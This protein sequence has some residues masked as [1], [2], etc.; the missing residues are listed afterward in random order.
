MGTLLHI[1]EVLPDGLLEARPTQLADLLGG[2][3]LIHLPGRRTQPLFVSVLLHGNETTG[4]QALQALLKRYRDK[5]LPRALS[6]FIG[7][8][9]AAK[10]G[11]RRLAGQPDYNRI[12]PGSDHPDSPEKRMMEEVFSIMQQRQPYASVDVHNN[13]GINPHYAC[14]NRIDHRYMHLASMF[15]RTLVYFIR[16]VGVQSMAFAQLCP[17]L[18][19]E[20]GK[21]EQSAGKVHAQEFLDACLHLSEIPQHPVAAHDVDLFHTVAIVRVPRAYSFG[22]GEQ[23]VDICF[24]NDL[25]HLNF[26]ELPAGTTLAHLDGVDGMPLE[27][28]D[29]SGQE[30]ADRYFRV[31]DAMLRTTR[32]LMPS[33]F[34]LDERVIRQDCLGYLMERYP[35][36]G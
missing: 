21:V 17:A 2:P 10:D 20:C 11:L 35:L 34:T 26:R 4:F 19:V 16:P 25:D 27:A 5:E 32:A 7:N 9:E 36:P 15:S 6:I 14:I 22:F 31:E 24:I 13:T 33:M 28:S 30:V 3:S 18:T 8:V 29:E 12:W 1:H 23:T